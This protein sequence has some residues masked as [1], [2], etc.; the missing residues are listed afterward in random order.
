MLGLMQSQPLLISGV[1]EFAAR[2]HGRAQIVCRASDGQTESTT[3]AAIEGRVRRLANALAMLGVRRGD[4][5]ATLAW[6]TLRHLELCYAASGMGAVFHSL[7]PRMLPEHLAWI[8]G[9]AGDG[10][11]FVESDLVPLLQKIAPL[12]PGVRTVIIMEASA[13]MPE[14]ALP[15]GMRVHC[16]EQILDQAHAHFD[17]PRLDENAASSLCYTSGT[18]GRPKGVLFSHRST[19]LHAMALNAADALGLRAA[20]RILPAVQM[21]HVNSVSV[22]FTAPMAGSALLLPGRR[23]DG[24][25]VAE[26]AEREHATIVWGTPTVLL[27]LLRHLD[28][29]GLRLLTVQRL[30]VGGS[31]CPRLLIERMEGDYGIAVQQSWGM[32]ETSPIG[33]FNRP[34]SAHAGLNAAARI[35]LGV[36]QGRALFGVGLKIVDPEGRELPWNGKSAGILKVRGPWVLSRYYGADS[37]D[38][39]DDDGW[40]DTGDVA[41]IDS[42]GFVAIV[43]RAKDMIKSG[44]E[45]ISSVMLEEVYRDHP[46]ILDLAAIAADHPQWMERPLLVVVPRQDRT[47]DKSALRAWACGKVADWWLPD[48][49]V[50]VEQ[51]PMTG[52]C[53]IDKRELRRRFG[54]QLTF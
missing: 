22:P 13:R 14:P 45:W 20:D 37:T 18:T 33:T 54:A 49:V 30:V 3:Y 40:F 42:D 4:R 44:G 39:A 25:A 27:D 38:A 48:A 10:V 12:V 5:V 51:L 26:F 53:K 7:N 6:H 11:L 24:P 29:S 41:T 36:K 8:V 19:V 47:P 32:T 1:L 43:D 23:L 35:D 21:F 9:H 28:Q 46:D 17:W 52:T 50:L 16:Y 15:P 2:H 31:A 34:T